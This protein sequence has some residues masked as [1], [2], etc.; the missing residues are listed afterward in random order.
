M[1]S[2]PA[3]FSFYIAFAC[4]R[5]PLVYQSVK[6][7][8]LFLLLNNQI[9]RG[10]ISMGQFTNYVDSKGGGVHEMSTNFVR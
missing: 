10:K 7:S 1:P 8:N 9:G 3:G 6:M 2:I 5:N 4:K